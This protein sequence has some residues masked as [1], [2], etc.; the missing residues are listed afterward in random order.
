M[1]HS[2]VRI[3]LMPISLIVDITISAVPVLFLAKQV[4]EALPLDLFL[5]VVV[6]LALSLYP[7]FLA[8]LM[9][10]LALSQGLFP[11][12]EDGVYEQTNH[13]ILMYELRQL[14][15]VIFGYFM[16][17][18]GIF[19]NVRLRHIAFGTQI[20]EGT[21]MGH[22]LLF[23]PERTIIGKNCFF[24]YNAIIT[25]HVYENGKLI[26]Q[27]VKIG[28]NCTIGAN[29]VI[30]PGVEIGDNV[31][32]GANTVIP[33]GRKIPPNTTWVGG[34][35]R[36]VGI[37]KREEIKINSRKVSLITEDNPLF[38]SREKA[39]LKESGS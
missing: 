22:A 9:G 17:L 4:Y 38:V 21:I 27:K 23:N 12:L 24:G 2:L 15:Y 5:I 13:V 6:P 28:D 36:Q 39:E 1:T 10:T 26:L 35:L 34:S 32:I 7:L 3:A 31:I 11:V 25:G 30:F 37:P 33:K 18:Y 19:L 14:Y 20:G 16:W 29:V 8:L